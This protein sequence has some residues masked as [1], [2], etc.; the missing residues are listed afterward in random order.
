MIVI[1]A[2]KPSVGRQI[3]RVLGAN[4]KGEGY[5]HG[6][7]YAV[8]WALGHLVGLALPADYGIARPA[9]A[10]LPV[11]PDP[12][13]WVVRR[14]KTAK[15]S[16]VD[17]AASRQLKVIGTL[18]EQCQS[19][20]AATDAGREGELIFRSI[21]EYSRCRKPFR[22]LWISSLTDEA[23][24]AG[25]DNLREGAHYEG[26]YRAADC[27]AKADWLIGINAS[28]ALCIASGTGNHSLGRVQT[29]TLAMVCSRYIEHRN[30]R[31]EPYWQMHITLQKRGVARQFAATRPI[32]DPKMADIT[33]RS[34]K[35][36]GDARITKVERKTAKQPPPPLYDLTGLQKDA[37][38]RLEM[39]SEQTLDVAQRL[40]ERGL[41]TYPRTGSRYIPRDVMPQIAPLLA[42]IASWKEFEGYGL[43]D[44][45]GTRPVD[46]GRVTDHHALLITGVQAK[47]LTPEERGVYTLIAARMLEAF[48]AECVRETA[49]V[50]AVVGAHTFAARGS[51]IVTPGWRGVLGR[52]EDRTEDEEGPAAMPDFAVDEV[53]PVGGYSLPEKKTAPKPLY[54]EAALLGAMECAGRELEDREQR[55]ALRECGLGTP[56]TRAA[57]L[58]TLFARGYIER[59]AKAIIPT[60]KGLAIYHAVRNMRVADVELT[61]SWEK[62]LAGIERGE[63]TPETFRASIEAYTRQVTAEILALRLGESVP[64]SLPCPKCKTG[65]VTLHRKIARCHNPNCG[66]VVFRQ[67]LNKTLTDGQVGQLLTE[68]RTEPIPGFEGK[69]KKTFEARIVFDGKFNTEFQFPDKP[70]T[71]GKGAKAKKG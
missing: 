68:G 65:R 43:P 30:F 46:D 6:G 28:Q 7:G 16:A 25:M 64:G 36:S 5:F 59:S 9:E 13:R 2:E 27:R 58:S 70:K 39:T 3:A 15:G 51:R 31:P 35:D 52:K 34:L 22:R 37:S 45:P 55:E 24:L 48:G 42:A 11:M 61:A 33:F 14:K 12:F 1:V 50:E 71:S 18:F 44:T 23:I 41:I 56:A 67:F 29:P 53:L 19:I 54:T 66:L 21:Y 26:L 38:T 57:I 4:N 63:R 47:G 62:D 32:T 49:A 20:I 69:Q 8:T 17:S 60:D 10:D 40:Y